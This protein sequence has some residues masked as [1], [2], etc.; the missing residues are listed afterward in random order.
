MKSALDG[1]AARHRPALGAFTGVLVGLILVAVLTMLVRTWALA[2]QIREAQKPNTQ[3]LKVITDCTTPGRACY[4]R[5][6]KQTGEAVASI[7]RVS[8]IAAAC[9]DKPQRQTVEQIQSCVIDRLAFDDQ[10]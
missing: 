10:S 4:E 3:A 9:A 6:Q 1:V 8:V 5:S 7:N 2:D